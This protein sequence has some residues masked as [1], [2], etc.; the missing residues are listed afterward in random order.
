[1]EMMVSFLCP[2]RIFSGRICVTIPSSSSSSSDIWSVCFLWL[3]VWNVG[4]CSFWYQASA[5]LQSHT[6]APHWADSRKALYPIPTFP[7]FFHFFFFWRHGL[8]SVWPWTLRSS[9]FSLLV[10]VGWQLFPAISTL[11]SCHSTYLGLIHPRE[12]I[13]LDYLCKVASRSVIVF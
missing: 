10:R 7:V 1:M 8:T 9:C 13:L 4:P 5:P 6:P 11:V 2:H 3:Q 12:F